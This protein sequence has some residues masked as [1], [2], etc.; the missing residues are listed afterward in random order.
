MVLLSF[1]LFQ[2]RL[3]LPFKSK[4]IITIP[5]S[6]L[7]A[8]LFI[9]DS[10]GES[11]ALGWE[12]SSLIPSS[13]SPKWAPFGCGL[14]C[15]LLYTMSHTSARTG[16]A[17][18]ADSPTSGHADKRASVWLCTRIVANFSYQFRFWLLFLV[19]CVAAFAGLEPKARG[20]IIRG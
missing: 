4:P 3:S 8:E 18:Q 10:L 15:S 11:V 20:G 13:K 1:H 14:S 19:Q 12:T 16:W 2:K 9:H 17:G 5:K 6:L 7:P